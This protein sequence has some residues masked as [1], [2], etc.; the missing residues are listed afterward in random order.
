MSVDW[1]NNSNDELLHRL[2]EAGID[3]P[4]GLPDA[5]MERGESIVEAL[6]EMLLDERNRAEDATEEW[7]W[8]RN[9][10]FMLLGL[11]GSA[12]AAPALLDYFRLEFTEDD[13]LCEDGARALG[14][15]GPEAIAPI[16][17]Y[18]GEK[19]RDSI[20][21]GVAAESLVN[22]GYFHP[23]ERGR[24]ADYFKD[25]LANAVEKN[26][27]E[28][29]SFLVAAAAC[30]DD[31]DVQ[32]QIE[33]AFRRNAVEVTDID[34]DDVKS[35]RVFNAPWAEHRPEFDLM[36]YFSDSFFYWCREQENENKPYRQN[37]D[38]LFIHHE[39]YRREPP[40]IGPNQPC[41][42][43]SGKKYKK[44]CLKRK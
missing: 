2:L 4:D 23:E 22:I 39:P 32:A 15:L 40:K 9:H 8:M 18:I 42:C 41:P 17:A 21:R 38:N 7:A 12:K 24:I 11:I 5:I 31:P 43:G 28:L 10:A 35:I 13:M 3:I 16:I 44:C 33:I 30:I 19:E 6:C 36:Y 1:S 20:L 26:D 37:T 14:R 27:I 25:A 29:T 34:E